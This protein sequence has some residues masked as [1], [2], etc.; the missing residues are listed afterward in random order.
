M[1]LSS[2]GREDAY[3]SALRGRK[4]ELELR[5]PAKTAKL[6]CRRARM[7]TSASTL[8]GTPQFIGMPSLALLWLLSALTLLIASPRIVVALNAFSAQPSP[9]VAEAASPPL[10]PQ[11]PPFLFPEAGAAERD[12]AVSCLAQAVYFEAGSEPVEGQ[13][14]V[15]QVVLNRVRDRNFP[16]TVCGVVYQGGGRKT[17]CQFSF[18]CDGSLTRRPPRDRDWDR[19]RSIAASALS[20]YVVAAIGTATHYHTDYVDPWWAPTVVKVGQVGAHIFYRWPGRAGTPAALDEA[21]YEG[22]EVRF[23]AAR[24][25]KP[26]AKAARRRNA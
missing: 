14:A 3:G 16:A 7:K 13:R 23:W 25:A 24:T 26:K 9:A 12:R 11:A 5:L 17:G 1:T 21:R 8:S 10:P 4:A 20:G 22:G 15:A 6:Y 19:A 18:V 2:N